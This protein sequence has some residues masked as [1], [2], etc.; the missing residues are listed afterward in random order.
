MSTLKEVTKKRCFL[1]TPIGPAD[2]EIRRSTDGLIA[3]VIRPVCESL[4]LE[5]FVA[6]EIADPGSIT[7]KVIEHLVEDELVI[8]NL[9][10]LN[11]N[12]MYELAV[13]HAKRLPVVI[14][15]EER[16]PLPF[17]V[18]DQRTIFFKNDMAG[19]HEL[20]NRLPSAVKAALND[21]LPDNP[22]YRAVGHIAIQESTTETDTNKFFARK[23]EQIE[24]QLTQLIYRNKTPVGE[25]R[26]SIVEVR[27][28]ELTVLNKDVEAF[29]SDVNLISGFVSASSVRIGKENKINI[30]GTRPMSKL[31]SQLA[32][33]HGIKGKLFIPKSG[34]IRPLGGDEVGV[35]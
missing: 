28:Y 21:N 12:V 35:E 24:E 11:P 18:S 22:I 23:L 29:M 14:I 16:T 8:A 5:F 26:N 17:D 1:I 25:V 31:I 20:S 13:R 2:S 32:T 9:T 19:V 15:A 33:K 7:T 3:S 4:G 34:A 27:E 6:H 30:H 10:T